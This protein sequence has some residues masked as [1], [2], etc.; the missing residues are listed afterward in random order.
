MDDVDRAGRLRSGSTRFRRRGCEAGDRDAK[1]G[2]GAIVD[3]DRRPR[4]Q[5]GSPRPPPSGRPPARPS[6]SSTWTRHTEPRKL[7][8][9]TRARPSVRSGRGGSPPAGRARSTGPSPADPSRSGTRCPRSSTAPSRATPGIRFVRPDE[10]G[11]E[12]GARAVVELGRRRD[13]LEPAG[14]HHADPVAERQRLLLVVGHEQ[15]RRA[16][17]DLDAADLL[18]ELAADLRV[19]RR[20][21]LVEQQHLGLDRERPRQRDAL[22]L[23]AGQLVRIS[24]ALGPDRPAR[25][26]RRPA[27]GGS[28]RPS[29]RSRRP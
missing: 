18:A 5:A 28:V 23:A 11:D 20:E 21:R 24:A 15:R 9:S 26:S 14:R 4:R 13:L 19:E 22:L 1:T 12:R 2:D 16:D 29:P 8:A 25:A 7:T 10:L 17:R 27:A 6:G 3:G